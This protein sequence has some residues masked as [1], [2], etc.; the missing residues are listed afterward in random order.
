MKLFWIA[1]KNTA[2]HRFSAPLLVQALLLSV[3]AV[4]VGVTT[5]QAS[6]GIAADGGATESPDSLQVEAVLSKADGVAESAPASAEM[7]TAIAQLSVPL[8]AE[9]ADAASVEP[10]TQITEAI[11]L[12]D[13][14]QAEAATLRD[15]AGTLRA[16]EAT[17]GTYTL[18]QVTS[19]TQFSEVLP[20]DW[21]YE[22][23]AFLANSP[24][25]GGLDCLEGY[26]DGSFRGDRALT[27]YEFAAGLAAC[28]D[29]IAG[30]NFSDDQVSRIDA[31]QREFAAELAE[32]RGR[33]DVL[34]ARVD[35]LEGNQFSTTTRL[36]G[37][38]VL[39]VQGRNSNEFEFFVDT[40]EDTSSNINLIYNV[41]LSLFTQFDP[42]TIL[43]AG[44][45]A[46]DGSTIGNSPAL[47][48]F[49]RL[50]Y[51]G[52]TDNDVLLSDLTVRHLIGDRFAIIAGTAGVNATN[53]FRGTN[54]VEGAGS[55]PLSLFAQRN[56]IISIGNG[57]G[58]VGFDWQ[59][60]S[61]LSLQGVYSS[62]LPSDAQFGGFFGGDQGET[63]IGTQL[64][65]SPTNSIDLA[66]QYI[67]AYSPFGRLGT[68]VGDDQVAI[69][70]PSFR[71]P[72]NTDAIGA[73]LT[74]QAA[75]TIS[76]GGW[77]GYTNSDYQGL[78]GSAETINWMLFVNV[79]DL[80]GEGNLAGLYVGQPPKIVSSDFPD[81]SNVPS[82]LNESDFSAGPGGQPGTS[83]HVE[84]F[85]R[86]RLT[87][88]ILLT[89]G[90]L[91]VF[92]PGHN[93]NNDTIF[94]GALRTTFLF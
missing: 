52:D 16:I 5:A 76:L 39:G 93:S 59:V 37:Q 80:F 34:E 66:F 33:V 85:Y 75:S 4:L 12:S 42:R 10:E 19:V 45:Q 2:T 14:Q 28:L 30:S 31:L 91:L 63:S 25:L 21:A 13:L 20:T 32:L 6:T 61:R 22:A 94:V 51:E 70:G 26:P 84:L 50:G 78:S 46:G 43:L 81:G 58:G 9:A 73:A 55:G 36:F 11:N 86:W 27:R 38:A 64:V 17:L 69:I 87:D 82:L 54:R 29:A 47:T 88:N 60:S 7:P 71:A 41:Q 65:F 24:D 89:P 49:F 8:E 35:E 40:L 67:N 23:L 79:D 77:L 90:F 72:I 15:S 83:T 18:S 68:G 57:T 62:S 56:P 48:N 3:S 53:V 74:W 44:L 92:D 1:E